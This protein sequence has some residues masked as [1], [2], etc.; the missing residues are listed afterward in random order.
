MLATS[1]KS[2]YKSLPLSKRATDQ[3][4]AE[5]WEEAKRRASESKWP[6]EYI[7]RRTGKP[8]TPHTDGER[9]FV[10]DDAPKYV[11][12]RGGWG[13]G[14]STAGVIKLLERIRRGMSSIMVSPDWPHF[15]KSLWPTFREWCPWKEVVPK[16]Q[17]YQHKENMPGG[18]GTLVFRNRAEIHYGG[19]HDATSWFGGNVAYAL[20]DEASRYPD[21]SAFKTLVSRA[22]LAGKNGEPPQ[23]ALAT[24]PEMNWLHEYF[25][26]LQDNDP[27]ASFKQSALV[28]TIQTQDNIDNLAPGYI[29]SLH[30]TLTPEEVE[31]YLEAKWVQLASSEKF[32]NIAWWDSCK[33]TTRAWPKT[34]PVVIGVDAAT[35]GKTATADCFAIVAVTRHPDRREDVMVRYCSIHKPPPHK[36]LDFDPIQEEIEKLCRD[37]AVIEVSYDRTQLHHMMTKLRQKGINAKEF[38]QG[39]ARE[40]ADKQ[41]QTLIMSRKIAHSG[42]ENLRQHI[43]NANVKKRGPGSVRII[44]RSEGQKVDGAVAL[45]QAV[46]RILYFNC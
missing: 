16:F 25:G 9:R 30:E 26:P 39:A 36:E 45:S 44:K 1:L 10:Y 20:F 27:L 41:L 6:D 22:R 21:A 33:E 8:Y 23:I 28:V 18:A 42:D 12:I 29:E 32:V 19:I 46:A 24:T 4:L 15:K 5:A 13:S 11:L 31:L 14:K 37:F 38:S 40:V 2:S 34:E 43:D 7:S 17:K 35:G 3:L